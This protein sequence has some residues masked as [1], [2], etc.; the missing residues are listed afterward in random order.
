MSGDVWVVYLSG[1]I[2]SDWRERIAQGVAEAGLPVK[3]TAPDTS[4]NG[5]TF[6]PPWRLP[7]KCMEPKTTS[8]TTGM[9]NRSLISGARWMGRR[10]AAVK[11][12]VSEANPG[13]PRSMKREGGACDV[14]FR[15]AER[16]RFETDCPR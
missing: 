3:L 1:E 16:R 11:P 15:E 4:S 5:F 8:I 14:A 7:V 13:K 9:I 6:P 2:H 12:E 10:N